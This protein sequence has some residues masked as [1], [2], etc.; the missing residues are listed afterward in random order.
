MPK[1]N[2]QPSTS[3][4]TLKARARLLAQVRT[5][6]SARDVLEVETPLL[7]SSGNSEPSIHSLTTSITVNNFSQ[8]FYLQT[9]P[10]FAMKRLLAANIGAIY[11][12]CKAF[13]GEESGRLHNPEFTL[14]EWYR[15]DYDHHLLMDEVDQLLQATL[16]T[17]PAKRV[18]YQVLFQEYFLI[19]PHTASLE[20]LKALLT[21]SGITLTVQSQQ[22]LDRD[23][24]LQLLLSHR[25]EPELGWQQPAFIYDYPA[26]Q[27][28]LARLSE[29]EPYVAQRFEVYVQGVEL[30][31]GFHE[32]T[33]AKQQ[34]ERFIK[35]NH[36]RRENNLP[37]IPL[38]ENLLAALESG[39]PNCAG[40]ALG[41]DRLMMLAAGAKSL[42]DVVAFMV[43][44]V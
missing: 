27:A 8:L 32:L 16:Q 40:V 3:I 34:R 31:N 37:E 21:E 10:E 19:N 1:T 36:Y 17:L 33:D 43:D 23:S 15:P 26:S 9:S 39:L 29:E 20:Q 38:D 14:L 35:Q 25:I 42:E 12:L 30:A 44:R 28:A 5:F 6:F 4:A 7:A 41:F 13:R 2:W 18:S 22:Q 24:C 11:Q